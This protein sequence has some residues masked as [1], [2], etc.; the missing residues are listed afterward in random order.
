M[1]YYPKKLSKHFGVMSP[2]ELIFELNENNE[3]IVRVNE[4]IEDSKLKELEE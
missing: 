3:I 4:V 2:C 1:L